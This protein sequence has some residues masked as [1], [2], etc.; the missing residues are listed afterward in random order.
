MAMKCEAFGRVL[1]RRTTI[2][3][4]GSVLFRFYDLLM[5]SPTPDS[6]MVVHN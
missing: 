2:Y 6:V 1:Q 5:S 3:E 4:D